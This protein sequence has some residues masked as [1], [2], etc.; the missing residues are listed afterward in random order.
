MKNKMYVMLLSFCM[1][2]ILQ[3]CTVG[4]VNI[5]TDSV[6]ISS[7]EE[8]DPAREELDRFAARLI[9]EKDQNLGYPVNQEMQLAGFYDWLT[10]SGFDSLMANNVGDPFD[11]ASHYHI[12]A[13]SFEREVLEFFGPLYGFDPEELWGIV[14]FS[15]T[16]GNNHGIYFGSKYL[17]KKTKQKPVVYV[18]DAAHYS[19]MR[20]A[21]LQ[22]L[23]IVLVP[24]DV[25][26]CMIPQELEK[27]LV[28]DRPALMVYAMGT[29]FKG[30]VDDQAAINAVLAKYPEIEV[31]RHVDAALFGGYLPY[32]QYRDAVDRRV[33][34]F[35][36]IAV[37]GHKFFGMD[38]PAGF[39]LTTKE[40]RDS[41]NPY[42]VPYL[43]GSMPM[44]NCS[45][46]ALTPLKFWWIIKHTGIEGFSEQANG[47]LERA[48]W[49]KAELDKIGW[50]AWLEPMS[51]TVYFKRPPEDITYKYNL[52][53]DQDERLGGDL[54]H[55]VVMQHVTTERL[56]GFL[57]DL[58]GAQ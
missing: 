42:N 44:I 48:A 6:T 40:I 21:D 13:L 41:Q 30:G 58:A 28:K 26:G 8:P 33:E 56:Q 50:P 34:P 32:T 15:G 25:H 18:S 36:S 19:N 24:S 39:F 29:T 22:N 16:D 7:P 37:S 27:V 49:L 55:I 51:N 31:Y 52:A 43:D 45:R 9:E 35:D 10:E 23:D 53:A 3:G 1:L 38:E 17:E 11:D 5:I 54:S 12:N 47:M 57:D 46:S 20:L 14:T 2:F 4:N